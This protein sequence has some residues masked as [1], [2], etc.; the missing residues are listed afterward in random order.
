MRVDTLVCQ[1][2][3]SI[4]FWLDMSITDE[5]CT[6]HISGSR[7]GPIILHESQGLEIPGNIHR[8][9]TDGN[10]QLSPTTEYGYILNVE[11]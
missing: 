11:I 2:R 8:Q 1:S 5:N 6:G 4:P 3:T 10:S 7:A 9:L